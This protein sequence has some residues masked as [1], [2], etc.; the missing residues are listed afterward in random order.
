[1]F[2]DVLQGQAPLVQLTINGT[3][4]SMGYYLVEVLIL[5]EPL[6]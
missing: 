3:P 2:N 6:L 1:M 4:H 5:I